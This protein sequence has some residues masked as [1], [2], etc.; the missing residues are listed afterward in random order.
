MIDQ[1]LQ[2]EIEAVSKALQR[3]PPNIGRERM[4]ILKLAGAYGAAGVESAA[5]RGAKP[6]YK[7]STPKI[8][9]RIRAGKGRGVKIATYMPGNLRNSIRVM[10]FRKSKSA[11]YI[12]ARVAKGESPKGTFGSGARADGYYASMVE[13]GTIHTHARPFYNRGWDAA[14]SQ[15]IRTIN[16]EVGRVIDRFK[17]QNDL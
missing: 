13:K 10:E 17:K 2:A 4:R 12:G 15:V 5:P 7:Y 8:T 9:R 14:R 3:L 16:N 1:H 11:V 6:H